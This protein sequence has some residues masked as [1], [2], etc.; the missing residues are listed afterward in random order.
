MVCNYESEQANESTPS[1]TIIII[2]LN[3]CCNVVEHFYHTYKIL[4]VDFFSKTWTKNA[5]TNNPETHYNK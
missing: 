4:K 3:S 5:K 1:L 2:H